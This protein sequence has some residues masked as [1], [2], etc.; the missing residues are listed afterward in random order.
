MLSTSSN[1]VRENPIKIA[2]NLTYVSTPLSCRTKIWFF[3]HKEIMDL[4]CCILLGDSL[5]WG[6]FW[7]WNTIFKSCFMKHVFSWVG[8]RRMKLMVTFSE[9]TNWLRHLGAQNSMKARGVS[10]KSSLLLQTVLLSGSSNFAQKY[11]FVGG[12][13]K[14]WK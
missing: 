6:E 13:L 5:K 9:T 1:R 14:K 3:A 7:S 4:N 8:G 10:I 12:F 2:K 11:N